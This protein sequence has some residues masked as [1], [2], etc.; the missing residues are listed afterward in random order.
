MPRQHRIIALL[1]AAAMLL[2]AHAVR[3]GS[4]PIIHIVV[5]E[6]VMYA[7]DTLTIKRGERVKWVN[8]DP[9]P[10]TVTASGAFDSHSIAAGGAW[11]YVAR[12]AGDYAY[13]CTLHPNMKGV[14]H[15]Q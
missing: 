10:H 4:A 7:P 5:I 6:G 2:P 3:A 1:A 11:T 14:L 8:K 13:A 12:K 15:V 9:F